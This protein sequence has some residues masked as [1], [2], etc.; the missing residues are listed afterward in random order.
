[1]DS[2]VIIT[3]AD[4]GMRWGELA[5]LQWSRVDLNAGVLVIDS[6]D[7]ALHEV[8]G[9]LGLGPP[10]SRASAR[11][12]DLPPFL[13]GLLDEPREGDP[14]A[15]FVFTAREGGWHRRG[16]FRRRVWLPAVAVIR[17]GDGSRSP[18]SCTSMMYATPTRPG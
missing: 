17:S 6:K 16:N 11:S 8:N 13:V 5:G 4:T 12:V 1:M 7:G 15:R 18:L 2:V 14:L 9:T 10:K 3:A